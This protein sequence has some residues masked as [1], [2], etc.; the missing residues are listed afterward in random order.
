MRRRAGV[1]AKT[2]GIRSIAAT[3]TRASMSRIASGSMPTRSRRTRVACR[4]LAL[5][6]GTRRVVQG[7]PRAIVERS[8]ERTSSNARARRAARRNRRTSPLN[9][10][11]AGVSRTDH[12]TSVRCST[13][14]AGLTTHRRSGLPAVEAR[15]GAGPASA[16]SAHLRVD[17]IAI[18]LR[19]STARAHATRPASNEPVA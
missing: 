16:T 10:P 17:R 12:Q 9:P 7:L 5:S 18:R 2:S 8:I 3:A 13:S 19:P 11:T 4:R 14:G 15:P 1:F 6:R